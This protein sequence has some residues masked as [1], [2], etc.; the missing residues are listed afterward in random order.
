MF[1]IE[2]LIKLIKLIKSWTI[3]DFD[4]ENR[5]VICDNGYSYRVKWGWDSTGKKPEFDMLVQWI[6]VIK[7]D[8]IVVQRWGC[9][10]AEDTNII[11]AFMRTQCS[12]A[13]EAEYQVKNDKRQK[14][15]EEWGRMIVEN[16]LF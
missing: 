11:L 2:H 8:G 7:K 15:E 3:I 16:N 10:D 5:E 9:V 1:K 13:K 6:L 4:F 12:R 14:L